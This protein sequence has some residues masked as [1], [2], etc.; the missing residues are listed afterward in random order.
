MKSN[1]TKPAATGPK[2]T[3]GLYTFASGQWIWIKDNTL[4]LSAN[5]LHP[6]AVLTCGR[7]LHLVEDDF[8]KCRVFMRAADLMEE[9]PSLSHLIK[10]VAAYHQVNP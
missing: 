10:K 7:T 4:H 8:G 9:K 3:D 1:L 5:F 2:L 6:L